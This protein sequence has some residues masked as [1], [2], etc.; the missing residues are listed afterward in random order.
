MDIN[1]RIKIL[2]TECKEEGKICAHRAN[3]EDYFACKEEGCDN[4]EGV[5]NDIVI[6]SNVNAI[7]T[8]T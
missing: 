4:Y 2:F 3:H 1:S 5:D 7:A 8:P 6:E